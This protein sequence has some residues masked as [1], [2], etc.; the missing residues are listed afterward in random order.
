VRHIIGDDSK[1]SWVESSV[2]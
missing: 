2:K 1:A